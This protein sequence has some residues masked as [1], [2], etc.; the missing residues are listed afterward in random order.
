MSHASTILNLGPR[1]RG[2][3]VAVADME[4]GI[5]NSLIRRCRLR[6]FPVVVGNWD[7]FSFR[8]RDLTLP[9]RFDPLPPPQF[10][11]RSMR[12]SSISHPS[13]SF[14]IISSRVRSTKFLFSRGGVGA[15]SSS[16][17]DTGYANRAGL[18]AVGFRFVFATPLRS[19]SWVFVVVCLE[20][21]G[22][23]IGLDLMVKND[24]GR[25]P[26]AFFLKRSSWSVSDAEDGDD[27]DGARL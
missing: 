16:S 27:G 20:C 7:R 17:E 5:V 6:F 12:S 26:R 14:W 3:V 23:E 19:G 4:V 11:I 1:L 13:T 9:R 8:C 25:T 18:A 22:L 10:N 21:V 24:P 2:A 15:R